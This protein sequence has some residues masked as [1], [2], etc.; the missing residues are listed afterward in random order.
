MEEWYTIVL[1]MELFLVRR[2]VREVS[3]TN[4]QQ[5]AFYKLKGTYLFAQMFGIFEIDGTMNKVGAESGLHHFQLVHSY[6][7]KL[8]DQY[9]SLKAK[10]ILPVQK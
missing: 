10:N 8:F 9:Y 7:N 2:R 1:D 3:W 5:I 6:F 4:S